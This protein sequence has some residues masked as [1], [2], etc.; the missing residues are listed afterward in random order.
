MINEDTNDTASVRQRYTERQREGDGE[1]VGEREGVR[2]LSPDDM[3]SMSDINDNN[4]GDFGEYEEEEEEEEEEQWRISTTVQLPRSTLPRNSFPLSTTRS[5]TWSSSVPSIQGSQPEGQGQ[6]KVRGSSLGAGQGRGRGSS[7][8]GQGRGRGRGSGQGKGPSPSK[9]QPSKSNPP[10]N[11]I[12]IAELKPLFSTTPYV[13]SSSIEAKI[14][15]STDNRRISTDSI[16]S[17]ESGSRIPSGRF[18]TAE[19]F[20][21]VGN[22][23]ASRS[24]SASSTIGNSEFDDVGSVTLTTLT[25]RTTNRPSPQSTAESLNSTLSKEYNLT[26]LP[27]PNKE[28]SNS[29][30]TATRGGERNDK[31]A[32]RTNP[33]TWIEG[34]PSSTV[35]S[36]FSMSTPPQSSAH[37]LPSPFDSIPPKSITSLLATT[38]DATVRNISKSTNPTSRVYQDSVPVP[39]SGRTAEAVDAPGQG[40]VTVR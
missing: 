2:G 35:S 31:E 13:A 37:V 33:T 23:V 36:S 5:S 39:V 28:D 25:T 19:D 7:P 16:L 40:S 32:E 18:L 17:R 24:S 29:N 26:S 14:R 12:P 20:G 21:D 3:V 30:I 8:E 4:D 1:G 10:P 38:R 34:V 11:P 9:Q 15:D 6:G 27:S 22:A